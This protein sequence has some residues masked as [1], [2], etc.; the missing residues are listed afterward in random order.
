MKL[1]K[2]IILA[3]S[4][5]TLFGTFDGA[6]NLEVASAKTTKVSKAKKT[7]KYKSNLSKKEQAA[8]NWIAYHESRGSYRARNEAGT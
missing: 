6:V 1:K 8:K 3:M 2:I 4:T 5:L 7:V